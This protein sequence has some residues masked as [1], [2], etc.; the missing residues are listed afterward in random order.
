VAAPDRMRPAIL[1][2][3]W[4]GVVSRLGDL[5]RWL[6]VM[7]EPDLR[8]GCLVYQGKTD[9]DGYGR[10]GAN[11]ELV[12]RLAWR[13]LV[14]PIPDD[15][16]LDH[17]RKRGC[18]SSACWAPWHLEEVTEAE[19]LRRAGPAPG[20]EAG[21]TGRRRRTGTPGSDSRP[22]HALSGGSGASGAA[23][24]PRRPPSEAV[25]SGRLSSTVTGP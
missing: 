15:M 3:G 17:V 16:T 18:R 1:R 4:D 24:P 13:L 21:R 7:T 8:A 20:R 25:A 5:P 10:A 9:G 6:L 14:G 19:N 2:D 22:A 12:H 11:G 23:A